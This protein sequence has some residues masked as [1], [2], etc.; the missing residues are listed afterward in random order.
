MVPVM[1]VLASFVSFALLLALAPLLEHLPKPPAGALV[2]GFAGSVKLLHA[3]V[4]LLPPI[5]LR[6]R[7]HGRAGDADHGRRKDSRYHDFAS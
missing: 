3:L 7:R 4:A 2:A 5:L 1:I 6:A